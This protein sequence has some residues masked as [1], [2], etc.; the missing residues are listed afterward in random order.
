MKNLIIDDSLKFIDSFKPSGKFRDYINEKDITVE[1][2][3][4]D[5]E[6]DDKHLAYLK[7]TILKEKKIDDLLLYADGIS[8]QISDLVDTLFINGQLNDEKGDIVCIENLAVHEDYRQKGIGGW[9]VDNVEDIL[10]IN[11]NIKPK[12]ICY[13]IFPQEIRWADTPEFYNTEPNKEMEQIMKTMFTKLGY[14]QVGKT[15][16]FSK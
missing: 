13:F 11:Y 1:I 5:E 15:N 7:L 16:V 3:I 10:E 9:L 6:K 2:S 4:V 12:I 14:K 8:Q